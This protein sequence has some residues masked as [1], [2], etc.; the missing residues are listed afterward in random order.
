MHQSAFNI[1]VIALH[2]NLVALDIE[3]ILPPKVQTYTVIGSIIY[4]F[5]YTVTAVIN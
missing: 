4:H 2:V 5:M 1:T 3:H